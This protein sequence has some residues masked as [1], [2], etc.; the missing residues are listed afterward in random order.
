M[1]DYFCL[2]CVTQHCKDRNIQI[3][4]EDDQQPAEDNIQMAAI[5]GEDGNVDR[6]ELAPALSHALLHRDAFTRLHFNHE[7]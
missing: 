6:A 5:D 7:R 2:C 1:Q 3:V 4:L